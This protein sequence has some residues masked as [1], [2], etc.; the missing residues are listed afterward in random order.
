MARVYVGTSGYSYQDWMGHFYPTDMEKGQFLSYYSQV[1]DAVEVNYTYYKMP[2]SY[3]MRALARK[4]GD[5]FAFAVKAHSSMTHERNADEGVFDEFRAA[6]NQAAAWL[7]TLARFMGD[8][9]VAVEFRNRAWIRES[10]FNLL[11]ELGLGFCSVDQPQLQGLM[12]PIARLT[13]SIAYIRFHGRNA[14]KWWEHEEAWERYDYLYTREELADWVPKTGELA[15]NA[16]V[17]YAFFNN[18]YQAQAVQ[19]ATLF[20]EMLAEAEV[21]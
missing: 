17:L 7:R 6:D 1:F 14:E 18:H 4:V 16:E 2:D 20:R 11:D 12:P 3:T 15:E 8:L 13:G 21:I 10:A 9:P 19:N 5:D